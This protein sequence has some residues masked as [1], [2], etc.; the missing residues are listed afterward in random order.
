MKSAVNIS[1]QL[2]GK[3]LFFCSQP[4]RE[5]RPHLGL[6]QFTFMLSLI[7]IADKE[8]VFLFIK[9]HPRETEPLPAD[10]V[11][12]PRVRIWEQSIEEALGQFSRWFGINS[13][14]LYDAQALGHQV[15][16]MLA[17]SHD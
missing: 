17:S 2:N 5:D 3:D 14:A 6:N 12:H 15:T 9:R 16:F 10:I 8:D 1:S 4:L 11:K 13:I 7:N